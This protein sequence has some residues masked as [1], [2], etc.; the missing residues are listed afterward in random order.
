MPEHTT[1]TRL[2]LIDDRLL[3]LR[4]SV[5]TMAQRMVTH[6]DLANATISRSQFSAME[7]RV[8][9]IEVRASALERQSVA[10]IWATLTKVAAGI[11]SVYALFDLA[12]KIVR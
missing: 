1:E 11:L 7:T 3:G 6:A 10:T 9:A 12:T 2:A 4:S 8:G 5:D